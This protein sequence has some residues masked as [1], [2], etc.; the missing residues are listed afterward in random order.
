ML[1]K[2][3]MISKVVTVSPFATLREALSLM[4]HHQLKSLVVDKT[5][6][7]D[8]Y[9][10]ITYTNIIKTVVAESGDIDLINVYDICAKPVISVGQSL[11]VKHVA[12]LMTRHR[13]KRVVVLND[14]DLIGL[15][16]MND[17]VQ[18]LMNDI[19]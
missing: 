1:V 13:V 5:N 10:L 17:I 7:H 4:K 12:S 6:E 15:V 3:V 2:D 9:G 19:E 11:S 8:A 16:C 18:T 14:N